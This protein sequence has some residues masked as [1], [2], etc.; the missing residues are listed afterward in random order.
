MHTVRPLRTYV[1]LLALGCAVALL[2]CIVFVSVTHFLSGTEVAG[3]ATRTDLGSPQ[4]SFVSAHST[5]ALRDEPFAL[6]VIYTR[7]GFA[8]NSAT[9]HV[10]DTVRFIN[11]T[12]EQ[13]SL[14]LPDAP[15][16]APGE[17]WQHTV[18][19][20]DTLNFSDGLRSNG[21]LLVQ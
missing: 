13:L 4:A 8:P 7:Q 18:T 17:F 19:Q 1:A 6:A 5:Q 16:L 2:F 21:K 11:D 9:V 15:V 12:N 10:G 20:A 14:T 3:Q